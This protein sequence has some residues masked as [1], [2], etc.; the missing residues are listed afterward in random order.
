[1]VIL[2][3]L[4]SIPIQNLS[5]NYQVYQNS[6]ILAT[7]TK[8]PALAELMETLEMAAAPAAAVGLIG[9]ANMVMP[10]F[11]GSASAPTSGSAPP[12]FSGPQPGTPGGGFLPS[13]LA[14]PTVIA[15]TSLFAGLSLVG[16]GPLVALFDLPATGAN[17]AAI[18]GIFEEGNGP[19][20]R[21]RG[22]R[23]VKKQ[24]I[25][26]AK[27]LLWINETIEKGQ[28]KISR[29]IYIRL[30]L[31]KMFFDFRVWI[32]NVLWLCTYNL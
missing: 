15:G 12:N 19:P 14:N 25:L 29:Y 32:P 5:I 13:A 30:S 10:M 20:S 9:V 28:H 21:R 18:A 31:C 8:K 7:T 17:R 4:K 16:A 24:I 3:I 11:M 22:K 2:G 1:M 23:E 6:F 26:F 27:L